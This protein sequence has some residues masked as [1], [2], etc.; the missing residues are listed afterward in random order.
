MN[1]SH[2]WS[3]PQARESFH[4]PRCN[5]DGSNPLI[6]SG[7]SDYPPPSLLPGDLQARNRAKRRQIQNGSA[8]Q[9][10]L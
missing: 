8:E 1:T 6:S 5:Y 7:S 10:V 4:L 3:D 9:L 2:I